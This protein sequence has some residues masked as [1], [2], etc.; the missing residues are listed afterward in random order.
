MAYPFPF[1]AGQVLSAAELNA[2]DTLGVPELGMTSGDYM[3]P[4]GVTGS[5]S[6]L[7]NYLHCFPIY[8][9]TTAT[10]DRIAIF[11]GPT[12]VGT[13]TVRIGIYNNAN[14]RPT[15]V[16]LDAGTVAVSATSTAYQITINETITAGWYWFAVVAQPVASSLTLTSIS[17]NMS[18]AM[19]LSDIAGM[20][21][22]GVQMTGVSGALPTFSLTA[23]V[24]NVPI[25]S[26][27]KA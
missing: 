7:T 19:S 27:R 18:L 9:P 6:Q 13:S 4:T 12:V 23:F 5:L 10:F 20:N 1:V 21:K 17:K 15:T 2:L 16:F 3:G 11:S 22:G 24:T 8:I 25:V 26:L 14:A